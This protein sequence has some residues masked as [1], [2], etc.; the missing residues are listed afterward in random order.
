MKLR[1]IDKNR[2]S[3]HY[4]LVFGAIVI[5]LI[6]ISLGSS[7]LLI[8]W[9]GSTDESN[10][11]LNLMGVVIAVAVVCLVLYKIRHH[12]FMDEVVY[13]WQLKQAL[14]RIYRKQHKIE[15]LIEQNNPDAM[16]IMNFMYEGSRQLY[17]L[18]DNT[19][20]ME[21]LGFKINH[22]ETR[23]KDTDLNISTDQYDPQ[24]LDRF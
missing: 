16:I 19:I 8:H 14:N 22:L 21:D 15:P 2:Y 13:V 7:T 12:P 10:F 4:K 3:R 5:A 20:T 24:M 1:E 17:Q 18:D 9:F 23:I 11:S 6:V